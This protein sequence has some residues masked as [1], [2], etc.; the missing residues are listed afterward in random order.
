MKETIFAL[1]IKLAS[2][3]IAGKCPE[4]SYHSDD[5]DLCL[6]DWTLLSSCYLCPFKLFYPT[7]SRTSIKKS[8]SCLHWRPKFIIQI[9]T[10]LQFGRHCEV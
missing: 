7:I 9:T 4:K 5:C 10:Y 6:C 2:N 3:N 1:S 8:G